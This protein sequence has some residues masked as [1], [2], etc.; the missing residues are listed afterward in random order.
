P[1][2]SLYGRTDD[3]AAVQFPRFDSDVPGVLT[4]GVP[5]KVVAG[6]RVT[7]VFDLLLAQYGVGRPDLPGTWPTGYDDATEPYTPGWQEAITGVP[8]VQARRIAREFADNA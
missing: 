6:K 2:L 1:L 5:T 7:T 4:R 3:A 8:A